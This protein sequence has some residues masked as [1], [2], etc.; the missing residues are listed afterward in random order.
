MVPWLLHGYNGATLSNSPSG[1]IL[2]DFIFAA[3]VISPRISFQRVL[4]NFTLYIDSDPKFDPSFSLLFVQDN[5]SL[6]IPVKFSHAWSTPFGIFLFIVNSINF[7][8]K[9]L[10]VP[11]S[12][13]VFNLLKT[14]LNCLRAEENSD[15]LKD[16][17]CFWRMNVLR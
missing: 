14:T 3:R 11:A 13:P 7:N 10:F 16:Y 12:S 5:Q 1:S 8:F 2:K 6:Q 4:L 9:T 15:N 17:L